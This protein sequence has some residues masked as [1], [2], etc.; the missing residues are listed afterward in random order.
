MSN[1]LTGRR[2]KETHHLM[3]KFNASIL[4][5]KRLYRFDIAG[6]IA[7]VTMLASKNIVSESEKEAIIK[8]LNEILLEMETGKYNPGVEHEDIHMAVEKRLT[9]LIGLTGGR[10]HTARSRNDQVATDVRL[11]LRDRI[12]S[13]LH[14]LH[15]LLET[16]LNLAS[17]NKGVILPG[18]THLQAAQPI[19][20]GFYYMTWFHMI[21]RD[22]SRFFDALARMNI[23]PLGS[24]AIAGVNY[25]TDRFLTASILG[26]DG[27][28]ENAMD[29]VADRDFVV[30]YVSCATILMSHLSR[31]NE[32]I[33][34]WSNKQFEFVTVDDAWSTGSS[35]MPNKKNPDAC[36]LL[37]GKTGRV[38]GSL[39]SLLTTLKSLP[40]AYNKDLQEDKEPLFDT[41]DT[42]DI[43]LEVLPKVL[44]TLTFH[45]DKMLAACEKGYIQATDIA[46]Y[47]VKKNLPFR[48]AHHICGSIVASLEKKGR[49]FSDM[50]LAEFKTFSPL[51]EADIFE[52]IKME[53]V[54]QNKQSFGSTGPKSVTEQISRASVQLK[55]MSET[56]HLADKKNTISI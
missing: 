33:I 38:T 18:F 45:P 27:P 54:L 56:L 9:D 23:S 55:Q 35:L 12:C 51:F 36:E 21:A 34:I 6:S 26:F 2:E 47:L 5:D 14:S 15:H 41:A 37:R 17:S 46:D 40:L 8:G 28:C 22:F 50:N 30:E 20:L 16:F 43:S 11:W 10:L 32:E 52:T 25:D 1:F 48:E 29:G 4:F 39:I 19:T 3:D 24:G 7:H 49:V 31:L 42:I 13:Q 44:E 53:N